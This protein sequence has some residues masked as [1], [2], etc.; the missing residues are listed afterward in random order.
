MVVG[1]YRELVSAM[2]GFVAVASMIA[3]YSPPSREGVFLNRAQLCCCGVSGDFHGDY[4]S[5]TIRG[6]SFFEGKIFC[7]TEASFVCWF[8]GEEQG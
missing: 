5:I 7:I 2:A 1:E 3:R 4:L 6:G 8:E